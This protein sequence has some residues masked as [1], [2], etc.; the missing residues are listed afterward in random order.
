MCKEKKEMINTRNGSRI[1]T[2]VAALVMMVTAIGASIA[3]AHAGDDRFDNRRRIEQRDRLRRIQYMRER[4]ERIRRENERRR[5]EAN[6]R[7]RQW[8]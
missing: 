7:R 3:P 6:N 5:W 2:A 1:A 4:N 8:K